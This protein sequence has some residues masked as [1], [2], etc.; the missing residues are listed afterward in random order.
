MKK[1][2]L[3][4]MKGGWFVGAFNP[5]AYSTDFEVGIHEHV[6]GEFH[7]DHFHKLGTEI[8]LVL[9]GSVMINGSVF[10]KDDI[11]ILYPYEVSIVEYLTD[12]RICV[13]RNKSIPTDKYKVDISV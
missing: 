13:V 12:V 6:K 9:D 2:N 8:N 1:F 11:F 3:K 7:Q 4:D 5:T 10:N